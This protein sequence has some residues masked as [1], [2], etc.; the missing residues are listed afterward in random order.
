MN[1]LTAAFLTYAVV[2]TFTPGPNNVSASALGVRVGYTASLPY[3]FGIATGFIIIMLC[4]GFLTEFLTRNY[5]TIA[6]YLKWV[7]AAYMVWLA[8]SLFF[9][10]DK[11]KSVARDG[12]A[13][14]LLLQF[15][16]P[17]G[18][19]YGITIYASFPSILTGG[20]VKTIASA[21]FLTAIGFLSIT[22]WTLIGS[23]LSRYFERPAFRIVFNIVM[24]L[25][26]G[27]SALSIILH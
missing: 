13:G 27:Y 9:H 12:Y 21:V 4:G 20:I 17:K 3:L 25:L 22:T 15:I 19:L 8:I 7:G 2:M 11:K 10:S 26:L 14:G 24:A 6:P 18:I 23:S 5:A 1:S 16:N